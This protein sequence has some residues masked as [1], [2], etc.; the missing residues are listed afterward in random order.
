MKATSGILAAALMLWPAAL[1]AAEAP[2]GAEACSGCHA[3]SAAAETPV[4]KIHGRNADEMVAAMAAFRTGSK[5]STVMDRIAKGFS[6]EE[7]RAIATWLAAQ[8]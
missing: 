8:R 2:P 1:P 3:V 5:P 4:P 6:E 7:T